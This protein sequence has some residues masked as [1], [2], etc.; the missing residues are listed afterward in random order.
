MLHRIALMAL[1]ALSLCAYDLELAGNHLDEPL[2]EKLTSLFH[3]DTLIETGTYR[4]DTAA[5]ASK[6]FRDVYTI[7]LAPK[8]YKKAQK[9]FAK[10]RNVHC[11][12]GH[13]GTVFSKLLPQLKNRKLLFWLDAHFSGGPTAKGECNTA[14]RDEIAAIQKA[15]LQGCV[16]L[17]DDIRGFHGKS[18]DV[19]WYGGYPSIPQLRDMITAFDPN[20]AFYVLG[21]TAIAFPKCSLSISPLVE[22]CTASRLSLDSEE[23]L[24]E[25]EKAIR[26]E[27]S[28][29]EALVLDQ[30][31]QA[32]VEPATE[33]QT[34]H[35]LLWKGLLLSARGDHAGSADL[36]KKTVSAGYDHWRVRWYLARELQALGDIQG[37]VAEL[38]RVIEAAPYFG[39]AAALKKELKVN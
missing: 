6:H 24:L 26:L 27:A 23:A 33:T 16:I 5:L 14:I 20:Y 8:L 39:A 28:T 11:L 12:L 10:T 30:I 21:D 15:G 36:L 25:A 4:G 18:E 32:Y 9:R 17:I 19:E 7:E 37:A 34:F 35:Y 22:A 31:H 29:P 38:D 13:S 3:V 2:M 1:S